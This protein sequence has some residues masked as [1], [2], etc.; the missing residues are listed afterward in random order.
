MKLPEQLR[1]FLDAA[2]DRYNRPS[3]VHA[4]PVSVP[5]RFTGMQDQ[6][7]AGF[8]AAIFSW[9]NRPMIIRKSIELMQL[10]DNSPHAFC[11][12]HSEQELKNLLH[13]KHRTFNTTD[14]LYF[15]EFLRHH[16]ASHHSLQTAFSR[17]G[18]GM[19]QMLKGFHEYFFSLEDSPGRTRKHVSTPARKSACKRLNMYLRWMVRSDDRGV[20]LG[21][22]DSISPS[23]LIC[24]VDLHVARVARQLKL[25]HRKQTDWLAAEEL[26]SHLRELDPADPVKYD[27]ALFGLGVIEKFG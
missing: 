5:H 14:L 23:Q 15:V 11:T 9:G 18:G 12:G 3:F 17:H 4:D 16:Y 21:I 13:F 24:P 7:I 20:D 19:A 10:M 6:E 8:F 25:L 2:V 26:T 27:L 22:W 1:S